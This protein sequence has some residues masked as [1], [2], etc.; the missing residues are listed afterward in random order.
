MSYSMHWPILQQRSVLFNIS[1]LP[2]MR[3]YT[4]ES[5]PCDIWSICLHR[6][7]CLIVLPATHSRTS[8]RNQRILFQKTKNF[9]LQWKTPVWASLVPHS[10][11]RFSLKSLST[12]F[13]FSGTVIFGSTNFIILECLF[14]FQYAF[15]FLYVMHF[16]CSF[17]HKM[18]CF[19]CTC[20][21]SRLTF[22]V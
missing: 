17:P 6:H 7:H 10:E 16:V 14:S 22:I 20:C 3:I 18:L 9:M 13:L 11:A 21:S 4:V 12:Y 2:H 19:M 15:E 5:I 8:Q 1:L